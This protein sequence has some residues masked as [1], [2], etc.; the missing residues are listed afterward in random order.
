MILQLIFIS[1]VGII[2][3]WFSLSSK[4]RNDKLIKRPFYKF[5]DYTMLVR[6]GLAAIVCV[7]IVNFFAAPPKFGN[8]FQQIN[9]AELRN[10]PGQ[11]EDAY[12]SL[13]RTDSTNPD[14]HYGLITASAKGHFYG[15]NDEEPK[16]RSENSVINAYYTK[17]RSNDTATMDLGHIGVALYNY[18]HGDYQAAYDQLQL[19]NNKKHK[20]YN[21]ILG[22]LFASEDPLQS[23]AY[24]KKEIELKGFMKGSYTGLGQLYIETENNKGLSQMMDLP[25]A[26]EY[27]PAPYQRKAAFLRM[28]PVSYFKELWMNM[29]RLSNLTGFAGAFL[30]MLVWMFYLKN[31]DITG[32]KKWTSLVTVLLLGAF[33]APIS[34]LLYDTLDLIV[35]FKK[36]G[37]IGN[38]FLYSVFGI[39]IVEE[40][41]K[42]LPF[43]IMLRFTKAVKTPIDYIVYASLSALGFA[44]AENILYF[45]SESLDIIHTRAL[46]TSISHMFDTSLI[47]YGLLLV[48]FKGLKPA[49]LVMAGFFGLAI[50]SHGFYDF[51]LICEAVKN[52]WF[53]TFFFLLSCI[54][55][56]SSFINNALNQSMP[57]N[58]PVKLNTDRLAADM[59][60]AFVFIM[61]FEYLTLG[62][63]YGPHTGNESFVS[64]VFGGWYLM[65]FL[66][67]RLSSIDVISKEWQPIE[68]FVGIAPYQVITSRKVNHNQAV[69]LKISMKPW[70]KGSVLAGYLPLEGT[71]LKRE[72]ISGYNGWFLVKLDTPIK[73]MD[74][75]LLRPKEKDTTIQ[76]N[77]NTI[78]GFSLVPDVKMLERGDKKTGDFQFVDWVYVN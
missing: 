21:Y 70:K 64:A 11:A 20:Y 77:M 59:I 4:L 22:E 75:I 26:R 73:G 43:L 36:N 5:G 74:H 38:D 67:L 41:M 10:R 27:V 18:Y 33:F 62:F 31:I 15:Y 65:F 54:L 7:F 9:Y 63:I 56:Y 2:F 3:L 61:L 16:D 60:A 30:I 68:Y 34:L 23:E 14:Y 8:P 50:L 29:Y 49:V 39:G 44:F 45:D 35:G 6:A 37:T 12:L 46:W 71:I 13:T 52:W 69:G 42:L 47:A 55:I 24:F 28:D 78:A 72:K 76:S 17:S 40:V 19:V 66:G 48:R 1:F 58:V 53:I 51:W 32:K 57:E 25:E